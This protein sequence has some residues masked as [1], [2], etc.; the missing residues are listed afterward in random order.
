MSETS[1]IESTRSTS[2]FQINNNNPLQGLVRI[3]IWN[4]HGATSEE[5]IQDFWTFCARHKPIIFVILETILDRVAQLEVDIRVSRKHD[6]RCRWLFQG[7]LV[8][9]ESSGC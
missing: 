6:T 4:T 9:M 1:Q 2:Q 5:S 8:S 7:Y 3:I